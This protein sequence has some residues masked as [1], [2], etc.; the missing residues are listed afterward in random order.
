MTDTDCQGFTVVISSDAGADGARRA[1]QLAGAYVIAMEDEPFLDCEGATTTI[2]GTVPATRPTTAATPPTLPPVS[3]P[4]I[5]ALVLE[6]VKIDNGVLWTVS[7]DGKSASFDGPN[8][9]QGIEFPAPATIPAAGAEFTMTLTATASVGNLATECEVKA[10]GLDATAVP[11]LH[12]VAFS[13][14][15]GKQNTL[16][17]KITLKP[18][19]VN[20]GATADLGVSCF[21]NMGVHLIYKAR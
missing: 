2:P 8:G 14:A 10:I 5:P 12:A 11:A 6:S 4:Q 9:H 18:R 19:N 16:T 20:P 7:A 1:T 21:S 13:E 17:V 15:P 3:L